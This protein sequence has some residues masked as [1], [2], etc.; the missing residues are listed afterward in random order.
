MIEKKGIGHPDTLA[1]A[2]A[3]SISQAY[4]QYS[5][6]T[7]GC[8]LRHMID[9]LAL[10]GGRSEV[11]FGGGSITE[12]ITVYLNGRFTTYVANQKVPYLETAT[13]ALEEHFTRVLPTY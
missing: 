9:K 11:Y 4:S 12:P 3:E 1:D 8:V 6:K 13:Q 7:Y 10:K 2:L 5:L